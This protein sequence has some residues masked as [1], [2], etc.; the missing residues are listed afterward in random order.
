VFQRGGLPYLIELLARRK[1]NYL[2]NDSDIE[3]YYSL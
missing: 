3:P 2:S 1:I